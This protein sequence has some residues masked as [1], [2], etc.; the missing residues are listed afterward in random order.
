[1]WHASRQNLVSYDHR[2]IHLQCRRCNYYDSDAKNKAGLYVDK[3]YGSGT[4][5]ELGILKSQGGN[6][7]R[8][9]LEAKIEE[10]ERLLTGCDV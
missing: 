8:Q 1:M 4:T 9:D 5:D 6:M 7:R 2:N 10:L 3:R